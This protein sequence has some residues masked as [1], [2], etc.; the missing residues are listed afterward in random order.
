MSW[1]F[2]RKKR[3]KPAN[4]RPKF[5]SPILY[6]EQL[7]KRWLPTTW[8]V[9]NTNDSGPGSLRAAIASAASTGDEV[10]FDSSL[11]GQIIYLNTQL[12]ITNDLWING[13]SFGNIGVFHSNAIG[14]QQDRVFKIA[15][16]KTVT[17]SGLDIEGGVISDD[18]G[19]TNVMLIGKGGGIYSTGPLTLNNTQVHDNT[20]D[21][22]YGD[23]AADG[24]GI[25]SSSSLTVSQSSIFHNTVTGSAETVPS[26]PTQ[27]IG[28]GGGIW[29]DGGNLTIT[30]SVV[31]NN[32]C[33]RKATSMASTYSTVYGGGIYSIGSLSMTDSVVDCN[34]AFGDGTFNHVANAFGGGIY[35]SENVTLTRVVVSKNL[36]QGGGG[37]YVDSTY[38]GP[39]SYAAGGG[40]CAVAN[41]LDTSVT[42]TQSTFDQNVAST[43]T[44][45]EGGG[46]FLAKNA[47]IFNSTISNN[48][49]SADTAVGSDGWGGGIAAIQV[50]APFEVDI[51]YCTIGDNSVAGWQLGTYTGPHGAG[52][53]VGNSGATVK[54]GS[55]ILSGNILYRPND[56]GLY[57]ETRPYDAYGPVTSLGYNLITDPTE[58]GGWALND[59]GLADPHMDPLANNGGPVLGAYG[60]Q[61]VAKTQALE[62]DSV[63]LHAGNPLG[64]PAT[65]ERGVIRGSPPNI[66]AWEQSIAGVFQRSDGTLLDVGTT[67]VDGGQV[68]VSPAT[69]TLHVYQP[70]DPRIS[71]D[72]SRDGFIDVNGNPLQGMISGDGRLLNLPA[73]GSSGSNS[74]DA[75]VYSSD[76]V[77]V[78]PI[79]EA[80]VSFDPTHGVPTQ[81]D[82]TL[83]FN[84]GS[85]QTTVNYSVSGG[86]PG[87]TYLVGDQ[88][89]NPVT[90]ASGAYPW[91]LTLVGHF[92]GSVT[93]TIVY[94]GLAL[95]D[96]ENSSPFGAGWTLD[97]LNHLVIQT[98]GIMMIFGSGAA[99]EWFQKD[100]FGNLP[101]RDVMFGT[102]AAV[103]GGYTYTSKYG[104]VWHYD[105]TGNLTSITDPHSL[106]ATYTYS[107][108]LPISLSWPDGGITNFY[109]SGSVIASIQEPGGRTL[110]LGQSGN[111]TAITD[112]DGTSR[113]FGYDSHHHLTS[114]IWAPTQ[115]GYTYDTTSTNSGLLTG[116][117]RGLG[118]TYTLRP[119][120]LVVLQTR[121]HAV[122]PDK[123]V[124]T[125][126]DGNTHTVTYTLDLAGWL[127]EKDTPDGG[128]ENW[129]RDINEQV[130]AYQDQ[131][132]H[133]TQYL[134]DN[135]AT[136]KGDQ[137]AKIFADGTSVEFYSYDST[138]H[139]MFSSS[140]ANGN[141]TYYS[142]NSHA[143]LTQ[144]QEPTGALTSYAWSSTG[145]ETSST[146]G[147]G[148][149]TTYI[150]S[151]AANRLLTT[152]VD[153]R[154]IAVAPYNLYT[155]Y[156]YDG[157]G[158]LRGVQDARGNW[159]TYT[160]DG[161]G[162]VLVEAHADNGRITN[163]Y[164][165]V[166]DLT[167][168][169]DVN[170]LQHPTT[171]TYDRRGWLASTQDNW[172]GYIYRSYDAAG[173][174]TALTDQRSA[175]TTY[176]YDLVNRQT[177]IHAPASGLT[178]MA[179][180]LA[181]NLIMVEDADTRFTTF[182][183]DSR[184]RQTQVEDATLGYSTTTYDAVGN[185]VTEE[186]GDL[187]YTNYGYDQ[188]NRQI[189]VTDALGRT[190]GTGYDFAG[191]VSVT[192]DDLG[193][194]TT[195]S[196][197]ADERQT[198][199][200]DPD[201]NLTTTVYDQ[202]G[203]ATTTIDSDLDYTTYSYD[204]MNRQVTVTDADLNVT[205]TVYDQAGN[206]I[207]TEEPT[208]PGSPSA[209]TTITFD[210]AAHKQ[211]IQDPAGGTST[212]TYDLA[213][214]RLVEYD[215]NGNV[216]SG[217]NYDADNRITRVQD[218]YGLSAY[219]YYDAAGNATLTQDIH[220]K[221]TS[222]A[223]DKLNRV[224]LVTHPLLNTER[225]IYDDVG[226]LKTY[227]V[228]DGT[229]YLTTTYD[230]NS[231]NRVTLV[232]H[233]MGDTEATGYDDDGRMTSQT[234]GNN[235]TTYFKYDDAGRRIAVTDPAGGITT[236][237]YD[238]AG[239][240]TQMRDARNNPTTYVY[241]KANRQTSQTNALTYTTT[242]AYD[243]R[244]NLTTVT[245]PSAISVGSSSPASAVTNYGYDNENRQTSMQNPNSVTTSTSYD[246]VGRITQK[247]SGKGASS[248]T[249]YTY[250]TVT[251]LSSTST[252]DYMGKLYGWQ[253]Y[254]DGEYSQWL[255]PLMIGGGDGYDLYDANGRQTEVVDEMT[256]ATYLQYDF[257]N[258]LTSKHIDDMWVTYTY[259][260]DGRELTETG[261][262][263][264]GV[265]YSYDPGGRVTARTDSP[266]LLTTYLY[267]AVGRTTMQFQSNHIVTTVYDQVGNLSWMK[268]ADGNLTTYAYDA[269]NE[270]TSSTDALGHRASWQYDPAGRLTLMTDVD[271]RKITSSYDLA[272]QLNGQT[273]LAADGSTVQ[274]TL[275][276]QYDMDGNVTVASNNAGTYTMGYDSDDRLTAVQEPFG[277]SLA[278]G[279][280][281]MGDLTSQTDNAGG[282]LT[283]VYN[284]DQQFRQVWFS[285]GSSEH[286]GGDFFYANDRLD[287]IYRYA[288]TSG[289]TTVSTQ[290][291]RYVNG[292]LSFS[293]GITYT[294]QS[295]GGA[296]NGS[297]RVIGQADANRSS[298][299]YLYD[300]IGQLT[301]SQ[302]NLYGNHTYAYDAA[303]NSSGTGTT[304][305]PGNRLATDGVYSYTYDAVG[306]RTTKI[307]IATSEEWTY[308]YD[309]ANRLT[310]VKHYNSSSGGVP[311]GTATLE[312]DFTYD[313]FGNR[314]SDTLNGVITSFAY[315][316]NGNAWADL[317]GSHQIVTRRI[318][319]NGVD[320]LFARIDQATGHGY[321][322]VTDKEGSVMAIVDESTS[323]IV[324]WIDYDAYGNILNETAA[325]YGDR[326]KYTGREW[327]AA[328]GLQ[329]SRARWY[330][331][332]T[333]DFIGPDPVSADS[334]GN[335]YRY[336]ENDPANR[337]DPL[338]FD[339]LPVN[340]VGKAQAIANGGVPVVKGVTDQSGP[341]VT[342][343]FANDLIVELKHRFENWGPF[344]FKHQAADLLSYK[345][346][347]F[348]GPGEP[349]K[350]INT[351]R[352]G[353][354]VLPKKQLGNIAFMVIGAISPLG[355]LKQDLKLDW[356]A[357]WPF[358]DKWQKKVASHVRFSDLKS[359]AEKVALLGYI[360][361]GPTYKDGTFGDFGMDNPVYRADNL[362]AFGVGTLVAWKFLELIDPSRDAAIAHAQGLVRTPEGRAELTKKME[363]VLRTLFDGSSE[364]NAQLKLAVN[365]Y[366]KFQPV[367]DARIGLDALTFTP[368]FGGFNTNSLPESKALP[369]NPAVSSIGA[370]A[371]MYQEWKRLGR[372]NKDFE[373]WRVQQFENWTKQRGFRVPGVSYDK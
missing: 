368:D 138:Y 180:D 72:S 102:L 363:A 49:A 242:M 254:S 277:M 118:T 342:A 267:D 48:S 224:T 119:S 297:T 10:V 262:L 284:Q 304:I 201:L 130:D 12:Y 238:K 320:Q 28:T 91:S 245:G 252:L 108:G 265:S 232:T 177:T 271:G 206:V 313:V 90:L 144:I 253:V 27:I 112:V 60:H 344:D 285:Q 307:N 283:Y 231:D 175:V 372:P 96:N 291:F 207:R 298:M 86:S 249:S 282:V 199:V 276:Y 278:Y 99:P 303:G 75:L 325:S 122:S 117:D 81:I 192:F 358:K 71:H 300:A 299:T 364:S 209:I 33:G 107:S 367:Q 236:S 301:A 215:A 258:R 142:Y 279:Y 157:N 280:D 337:V 52:L 139:R 255:D 76:R 31:A 205:T 149:T 240:V 82:A 32:F 150:Y 248:T 220:G 349:S 128:H 222:Y 21:G 295:D 46:L 272:G 16:G 275:S 115:A 153:P 229:S 259:D 36:A 151:V 186:N 309:D 58:S 202:V 227:V 221:Y 290:G 318:F 268:D 190:S 334:L 324:D 29:N 225:S 353:N 178:T 371:A 146:D 171:N 260:R 321:F 69:G 89:V 323:A 56:P 345:W 269:I 109:Y 370:A 11:S 40:L 135:S 241:D 264:S 66:G 210:P 55:T 348:G 1:K 308:S 343:W 120:N 165:A 328:I 44:V 212:L 235:L 237:I 168:Y 145:L 125:W 95:V 19:A 84:G 293:F 67:G 312:E 34:T 131:N 23:D 204:G 189:S 243:K 161:R 123:A 4:K 294:Y 354:Y 351:V 174:L 208:Q 25:F 347:D 286:L 194:R 223:Y 2:N 6:L 93:Q 105:S 200:Q 335:T 42:I 110:S 160:N 366:A 261:P 155:T 59:I 39:V 87:D 288:D 281:G 292:R 37:T 64:A 183:Y 74:F 322:Y 173:N 369:F 30:D 68:T 88:V 101:P 124:A 5:P 234:D 257:D 133:A 100:A 357:Y 22:M 350:G 51:K 185:V 270:L 78:R 73:E 140:D 197:D 316:Q 8:T 362:A 296:V 47:L 38:T 9:V 104:I 156:A 355:G 331:P 216:V 352:L 266:D 164:D 228:S 333:R 339:A 24:G 94:S 169:S 50:T 97:G 126:T 181:G 356:E 136:G 121:A 306:N 141:T 365:M 45:A 14:V 15:T 159:T 319:L 361:A 134:F 137:F 106:A 83:V 203:N 191:N 315:D 341:D 226:N 20:A 7:E 54:P 233:P 302:N 332:V 127:R 53:Y 373:T 43:V 154:T 62:D 70:L 179:Y 188:E 217:D 132:G 187:E 196:Y 176:S 250:S 359:N 256:Y 211:T 244:G 116:I 182:A 143:D 274:D 80:Y 41:V 239:N 85:P 113:S 61:R 162:R 338:G 314:L 213:G 57:I 35:A 163:T 18:Q 263:V 158:Y 17:L 273:W 13:G 26:G 193:K 326:Y 305:S 310:T 336:V 172:G 111:L 346:L 65:D 92:A 340:D 63:A 147:R 327:D 214:N 195:Y 98:N 3:K 152:T 79:A 247:T 311:G 329:Y 330:D 246:Y 360:A 114:L 167:G 218:A 170:P 129:Y 148:F 198:Q 230:Y 251:G 317:N 184:N 103:S 289:A 166:G 219:T 77:D 287:S